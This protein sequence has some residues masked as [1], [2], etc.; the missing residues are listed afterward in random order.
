[1]CR[2][3]IIVNREPKAKPSGTETD[4]SKTK[5]D[6]NREKKQTNKQTIQKSKKIQGSR[7][8]NNGARAEKRPREKRT[9]LFSNKT[10]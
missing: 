9:K 5:T 10:I 8:S 1:M 6:Q 4:A 7:E 3:Y 2:H